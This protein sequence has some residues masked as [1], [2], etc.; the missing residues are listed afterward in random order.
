MKLLQHNYTPEQW[1]KILHY[2]DLLKEKNAVVNLISRKDVDNV[3][4]HH[5]APS[6]AFEVLDRIEPNEYIID[7]GSGGGLPGIVNA[8]LF[9]DSE[10]LLVDSTKKKVVAMQEMITALGLSNVETRWS[11]VEE[12]AKDPALKGVFDRSTSRAV[13][14]MD[15]LITWSKP[16]LKPGGWVEALKGGD[17]S[18]ELKHITQPYTIHE[19]PSE[20]HINEKLASAKIISVQV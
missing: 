11:R 17:V 13:A 1:Q 18:E 7:I 9:P 8:I 14:S 6:L 4:E 10:F 12:L 16:L 3:L 20:Y 2:A 5:I 19:F 15:K